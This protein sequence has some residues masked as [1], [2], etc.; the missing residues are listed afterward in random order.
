MNA[1]D[2]AT[3]M[4]DISSLTPFDGNPV[5]R[6]TIAVTNAGDGLSDALGIEPQEFHHGQRVYVVL[7]CEVSRV[8]HVPVD[9]DT[10]G[11]LIRQHTLRAGTGTIVDA[12]LVAEQVARQAERIDSARRRAKGEFTLDE[13]QLTADHEEGAHTELE[14]GC[15][16]CDLEAAAV[17]AES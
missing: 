6:T 4:A 13:A 8:A 12:D 11:I 10:P 1:T 7:E 9:K 17:A 15:P 2:A 14:P 5:V 3:A 16:E